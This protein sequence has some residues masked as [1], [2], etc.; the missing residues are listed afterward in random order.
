[1]KDRALIPTMRD[2]ERHGYAVFS[3]DVVDALLGPMPTGMK[4]EDTRPYHPET[5][6][7]DKP[8]FE[9][10]HRALARKLIAK[11]KLDR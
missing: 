2:V 8:G 9:Y 11:M 6:P 10:L 3:D 4:R 5:W 1:M 7:P